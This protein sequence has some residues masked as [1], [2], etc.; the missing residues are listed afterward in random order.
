[1]KETAAIRTNFAAESGAK[2][3]RNKKTFHFSFKSFTQYM[4]TIQ[5][6][7]TM[8]E[9]EVSQYRSIREVYGMDPA[10]SE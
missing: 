3:R 7:M 2:F 1:M 4:P 5:R 9:F 8:K 10:K 6:R